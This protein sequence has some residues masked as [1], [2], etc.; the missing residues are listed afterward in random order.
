[1]SATA[2]RPQSFVLRTFFGSGGT[3]PSRCAAGS[4]ER[5]WRHRCAQSRC[6]ALRPYLVARLN[7]DLGVPKC[8]AGPLLV[9]KPK[10][11]HIRAATGSAAYRTSLRLTARRRFLSASARYRQVESGSATRA[12]IYSAKSRERFLCACIFPSRAIES[13][14]SLQA[15]CTPASATATVTT[16]HRHTAPTIRLRASSCAWH[17]H[18]HRNS[19]AQLHC[20]HAGWAARD[21]QWLPTVPTATR[22]PL[23]ARSTM[24]HPSKSAAAESARAYLVF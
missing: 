8:Q 5:E 12:R 3:G 2:P 1:M 21:H 23:T 14:R 24:R 17:V 16:A 10:A 13:P 6:A 19:E 22:R 9:S 11:T 18:L 7:G 15:R 4:S 20:Q